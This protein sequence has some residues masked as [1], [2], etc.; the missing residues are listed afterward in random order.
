[1]IMTNNNV[2]C[3]VDFVSINERKARLTAALVFILLAIYLF[4]GF[5]PIPVF[6]IVD[7]FVRSFNLGRFSPLG[8]ISDQLIRIFNIRPKL[9]DQAPKRFAAKTG[10]LFSI[11]IAGLSALGLTTASLLIASV[12]ALFAL[13]ESALAFCACVRS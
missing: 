7:F 12:M 1:M 13:L 2:E 4:T 6:L 8:L 9:T 5:W 11:A 3:P 10:L